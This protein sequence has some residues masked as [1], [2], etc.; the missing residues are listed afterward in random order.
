MANWI[1]T[2]FNDFYGI[3]KDT[4]KAPLGSFE[5]LKNLDLRGKSGELEL[6]SGYVLKYD[7]IPSA[8]LTS[9]KI[10]NLQYISA[11]NFWVTANG[12][13]QI[14]VQLTKQRVTAQTTLSPNYLDM[15]G[16]WIRPY[17]NGSSWIDEWHWLNE[18]IITKITSIN[19]TSGGITYPGVMEV[20]YQMN[21]EN[22]FKDYSI[23]RYASSATSY[24]DVN[25]I[26]S[27]AYS[28][29]EGYAKLM[30]H[31]NANTWAV[32]DRV[33]LMRNYLP[34]SMLTEAFT[35][36]T[37]NDISYHTV[38]DDLRVCLG[39]RAEQ[40][41]FGI[42]F[43]E[44][45]WNNG[46]ESL[47][48]LNKIT[49]KS[50]NT[51]NR[52]ILDPYNT[53]TDFDD[54]ITH[55]I[56]EVSGTGGDDWTTNKFFY[57]ITGMLDNGQE[58]ILVNRSVNNYIVPSG[59]SGKKITIYARLLWGVFNKR[60][61]SI[62]FYLSEGD[63]GT[64][65]VINNPFYLMS[66][67]YL[68]ELEWD[69][70]DLINNN[71]RTYFA[72]DT[73]GN[74]WVSKGFGYEEFQ[75]AAVT[76]TDSLGYGPAVSYLRSW[77]DSLVL[78]N[79]A[80]YLNGYIDQEHKNKV[81]YSELSG[82]GAG[83][84]DVVGNSFFDYDYFSGNEVIAITKH[85]SGRIGLGRENSYNIVDKTYGIEAI[86]GD[87][88]KGVVNKN[89]IVNRGSD[90]LWASEFAIIRNQ[91]HIVEDISEGTIRGDYRD[92]SD[93]TNIIATLEK[94]E[95]SFRFF[96]GV[97]T[98]YLLTPKGWVTIDQYTKPYEYLESEDGILWFTK[99]GKVYS[100][101][102]YQD[103]KHDLEAYSSISYQAKTMPIDIRL[104]SPQL[105]HT[106]TFYLNGVWIKYNKGSE[107]SQLTIT[108]YL[109][110]VQFSSESFTDQYKAFH[111]L[112]LG[113][114]C[115]DFQIEVTGSNGGSN[116][117]IESMGVL[118]KPMKLG[119][120]DGRNN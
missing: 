1:E 13:R 42:G 67:L 102:G 66:E 98:E 30:I 90:V 120:R 65:K 45:Y 89:A 77:Q 48:Y 103:R 50:K 16:I 84:L 9:K 14:T 61:T 17:W 95:T 71:K 86:S 44:K 63:S 40:L 56:S 82:N 43:R 80:Y 53:L 106:N 10:S 75:Q 57:M 104:L 76:V 105:K 8:T 47:P 119:V 58:F 36:T 7:A 26:S 29:D 117:S 28:E 5:I 52:M 6:R 70:I 109:D 78:D 115:K 3:Q 73:N 24:D 93:K 19:G 108:T 69:G 15:M 27:V 22:Q 4:R 25:E 34:I 23:L 100:Q 87:I 37:K 112:P 12:G 54:Y 114:I 20:Y 94:K 91:N 32:N 59:A 31:D 39:N 97:D 49:E 113:A 110:G 116:F 64:V 81:F 46:A 92:I 74:Y 35:N 96:D 83:M 11:Y 33:I 88:K 18:I 51:V 118:W 62:R 68:S 41:A 21:A 2:P 72:T 85:P 111:K 99:D 79:R 55:S 101:E 107:V 60:L 38:L